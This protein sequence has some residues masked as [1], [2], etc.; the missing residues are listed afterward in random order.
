M[1]HIALVLLAACADPGLATTPCHLGESG[2]LCF[3]LA[4]TPEMPHRLV[5]DLYEVIVDRRSDRRIQLEPL[6]DDVSAAIDGDA[7]IESRLVIDGELRLRIR[8]NGPIPSTLTIGGAHPDARLLDFAVSTEIDVDDGG[9]DSRTLLPDA[10]VELVAGLGPDELFSMQPIS[11]EVVEGAAAID[12]CAHGGDGYRSRFTVT[13]RQPGEA[14]VRYH[15]TAAPDTF[16]TIRVIDYGEVKTARF[17]VREFGR[18][19][20]F[21]QRFDVS[22]RTGADLT[23]SLVA[24]D[25]AGTRAIGGLTKLVSSAPGIVGIRRPLHPSTSLHLE[26][27]R[28]GTSTVSAMVGDHLV[29]A[30]VTVTLP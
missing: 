9:L 18:V 22:C 26:C 28:R 6:D 3:R 16:D 27:L 7:T 10:E 1:K 2:E 4:G 24:L 14:Q 29:E 12:A 23:L 25:A 19:R 17:E 8:A 11:L 5:P 30:V 21:G 13:A 20:G 15:H